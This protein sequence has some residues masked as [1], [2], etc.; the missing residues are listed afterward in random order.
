MSADS[1][2]GTFMCHHVMVETMGR[3]RRGA[4]PQIG[5]RIRDRRTVLGLSMRQVAASADI[6]H[7]TLGRMERGET[8]ADNRF[9]L[10]DLA[11]ALHCAVSDLT[12]ERAVPDEREAASTGAAVYDVV[13]AVTEA[14][15]EFPSL[16]RGGAL[17]PLAGL[18]ER[19]ALIRD[20]RVQCRYPEVARLLPDAVHGLYTHIGGKDTD[21]ALR[22]LIL[23]DEVAASVMR[24]IGTP[25]GMSL[26]AERMRGA[27]RM[28]GDP[29]LEAYSLYT[30]SHSALVCGLYPR[31]QSIAERG[32]AELTGH[33]DKEGGTE[34]LGQLCL[35]IAFA[36]NGMGDGGEAAPYLAEAVELGKRTGDTTVLSLF[37]GPT[38]TSVWQLS[39]ETDAGDPGA[40]VSRARGIRPGSLLS[41][42][43][44]VSFFVDTG[45]ALTRTG[46]NDD[47]ATRMILAGERLAP[48]RVRADP[49]VRETA[50]Y[51]LDRRRRAAVPD[52]LRGLCERVGIGAGG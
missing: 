15:P 51:L 10:A 45:R 26:M 47:A 28:L 17:M 32:I 31:A 41:V 8:S 42:S 40:A 30:L 4:D 7:M 14:D 33:H 6:S 18:T 49:L 2:L 36:L 29:V 27:A 46:S 34:L 13:T 16:S 20:L 19:V 23:V 48:A 12:G 35:T 38:N 43:R 39:M 5:Q 52:A 1:G 3:R 25:T 37:F 24:Y 22:L 44:Q 11:S 21:E 9:I 50:R